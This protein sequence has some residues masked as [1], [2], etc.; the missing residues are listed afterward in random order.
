MAL[1]KLRITD[2]LAKQIEL[3]ELVALQELGEGK[4]RYRE[5]RNLLARFAVNPDNMPIPENEARK[6]IGS[7]KLSELNVVADA[8]FKEVKALAVNPTN[9]GG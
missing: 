3:D 7:L 5:L 6:L 4:S 9:G 8:F 2:E 1:V